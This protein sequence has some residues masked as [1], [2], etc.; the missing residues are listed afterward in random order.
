MQVRNEGGI[1]SPRFQFGLATLNYVTSMPL[2]F[3]LLLAA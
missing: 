1:D 3:L 2:R